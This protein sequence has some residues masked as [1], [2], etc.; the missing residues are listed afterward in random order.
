MTPRQNPGNLRF[1]ASILWHG[2]TG[3]QG[4]FVVFD[5]L[6]NGARALAIDLL[7][8][9]NLHGLDTVRQIVSTYAPPSEN[10]T[11]AYIAAVSTE[12]KV[13]PDDWLDLDLPETLT[14]LVSAVWHHEQGQLP[15]SAAVSYGVAE[16]LRAA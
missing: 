3:Q 10:D 4:G 15:D 12:M 5:T 16:A 11:A 8:A 7:N 14:A 2:Q 6:N 1:I 13:D 9:Q